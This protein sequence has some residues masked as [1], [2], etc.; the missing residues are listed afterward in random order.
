MKRILHYVMAFVVVPFYVACT[1]QY[2]EVSIAANNQSNLKISKE[3]ALTYLYGDLR[4]VDEEKTRAGQSPRTVKSIKQ[5]TG[6]RTRSGKTLPSDLLYIVEF[7]EGRGSA[8]LS[9]DARIT[10]VIAI[11]DESVL[12]EEDFASSN[13][14]EIGPYVASL[15]TNHAEASVQNNRAGFLPHPGNTITDT[16]YYYNRPAF[17]RTKWGQ[18]SPYNSLCSEIYGSNT[19]V[20][21]TTVAM[22]QFIYH[23]KSEETTT[24]T[25]NNTPIDLELVSHCEYGQ[26]SN[27]TQKAEVAKL[28]YNVGVSLGIDYTSRKRTVKSSIVAAPF[29]Q[30]MG[31]NN[32]QYIAYSDPIAQMKIYW[33]GQPIYMRGHDC[34]SEN[35]GHAWLLDGWFEYKIACPRYTEDGGVVN[36]FLTEKKVH[37]NFGWGGQCDGY[38]TNG[39][40]DTT[41]QNSN[42][43][44]GSGDIVSSAG[45]NFDTDLYMVNY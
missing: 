33:A 39:I 5:L 36:D 17:L 2:D 27:S 35:S 38:Y 10:P 21:C 6:A 15:I 14:E 32:A 13:T 34:N 29:L 26:R 44:V 42:I 43:E 12:T 23:M 16:I 28:M 1:Q 8:V 7:E 31:F 25:I 41:I 3:Q 40:Y 22:S 9:A 30:S 4:L 24:I 11:L 18:G 37:C 45:Y 20:G 19:S